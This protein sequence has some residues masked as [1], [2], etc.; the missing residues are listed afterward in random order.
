MLTIDNVLL[1]NLERV[2]LSHPYKESIQISGDKLLALPGLIDTHVHFRVP[3]HS[4]KEDWMHGGRAAICGGMTTVFDM[5]NNVP[6][7]NTLARLLNKKKLIEQQ[8]ARAKL[9]LHYYLYFS[10]NYHH[11]EDLPQI[12]KH[13]IALKVFLGSNRFPLE[14]NEESI[15]HT[16][17]SLAKNHGFIIA[18]HTE[19]KELMLK[20]RS[21]LASADD[22]A[23]H[24]KILTPEV[25]AQAIEFA[26]QLCELYQVPTYLLHVSSQMDIAL[27]RE[28]KI[29]GLPIYAET[30][31]QYLFFSD[32][33]YERLK[34][35][36]KLNPPLRTKEDVAA[37][38]SALEDGTIDVLS[39][40][41]APH[42]L[43]LKGKSLSECPSGVPGVETIL[44]LM[45]TAWLNKKIT[46]DKIIQLMH[47]NPKT[48]F[49]LPSNEDLVLVNIKD[50]R[51]LQDK[52]V[53]S[54]CAWTPYQGM[55]LT[56]FPEYVF[57]K[58]Q[59]IDC[60]KI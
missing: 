14:M 2:N 58:G 41:H 25:S 6:P 44:P 51:V 16:V 21:Q 11:L 54:K 43:G 24:S 28:A 27:I 31:P 55:N 40:N 18:L 36:G 19:N 52:D 57:V 34:G 47:T 26:I 8:L 49:K 10:V 56:G 37:L 33:D 7:T 23:Y 12:K 22:Y 17:Y 15:L 20:N 13:V 5:P 60:R 4:E 59:L 30:C 29:Q 53:H 32:E 35:R 45:I 42:L 38:W 9:P 1:P 50:Y 46:L 39:S 3:G 48:I